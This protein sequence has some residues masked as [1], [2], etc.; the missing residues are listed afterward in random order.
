MEYDLSLLER[1]NPVFNTAKM[2]TFNLAAAGDKDAVL[3]CE[4]LGLTEET[5]S[6]STTT[7]SAEQVKISNIT[8]ETRFRSTFAMAEETGYKTIIDLPCGY[9]SRGIICSRK[10]QKYIGLDLPATISELEPVVSSIIAPEKSDMIKYFGVDATNYDSLEKALDGV[11][12][13]VCITT[14]GLL[15][16]FTDS[17][18]GALCDNIRRILTKHGGC[19]I[20]ADPE[21]AIQYVMTAMIIYGDQFEKIMMNSSQ[22][23]KDKSDV[24]IGKSQIIVSH[25][26]D[27]QENMKK[28]M[29]FLAAHGLKAERLIVADYLPDLIFLKD[30][31]ELMAAHRQAMSKCAFWKITLIDASKD[32]YTADNA[33]IKS[34]DVK[35]DLNGDALN[36]AITGRVDT[37]TAPRILEDFE[38]LDAD[39]KIN[40]VSIDCSGLDYIS[41]AGLRVLLIMQ[42]K[43]PGGVT[44]S[45]VNET[46]SEILE[47]TGFDAFFSCHSQRSEES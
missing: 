41:S 44:L 21:T 43:C 32:T 16:Y 33:D 40:S 30:E 46:V 36:M 2:T 42:K 38:K 27:V 47:Q 18:T 20:T 37:L 5:Q 28:A 45:G 12:G 39:E 25:G 26:K 22:N 11:E 10:G 15:M 1:V 29:A 9:T 3:I 23:V 6:S 31:P 17:E 24:E 7:A 19:W 4:R 14:E 34:F 13:E 35:T 8:V